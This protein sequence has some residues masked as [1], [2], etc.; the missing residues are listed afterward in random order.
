MGVYEDE[1]A[2]AEEAAEAAAAEKR[3]ETVLAHFGRGGKD[4]RTDK[5]GAYITLNDDEQDF[6]AA[7]QDKKK[8]KITDDCNDY[9]LGVIC[10]VLGL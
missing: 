8:G 6:I 2:K 4:L 5:A 1:M 9:A 7:R 3:R 10:D